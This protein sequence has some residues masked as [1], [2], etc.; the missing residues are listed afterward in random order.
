MILHVHLQSVA[1][2]FSHVM[3][4]IGGNTAGPGMLGFDIS[5]PSYLPAIYLGGYLDN[6]LSFSLTLLPYLCRR[7]CCQ[8]LHKP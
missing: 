6:S 7:R 1:T 4:A 8:C 5:L 3:A 2:F